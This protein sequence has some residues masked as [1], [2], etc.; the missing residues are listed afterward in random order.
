MG[1]NVFTRTAPAA[2]VLFHTLIVGVAEAEATKIPNSREGP[3]KIRVLAVILV[4]VP[5]SLTG[6][7]I[8]FPSSVFFN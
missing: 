5:D 3:V 4:G 1:V 8:V 2:L 7:L 6:L